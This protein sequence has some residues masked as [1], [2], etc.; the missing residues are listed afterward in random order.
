[1]H[2]VERQ[3]EQLAIAGLSQPIVPSYSWV[4]GDVSRF[5]LQE[6][7]VVLVPGGARHRPTKRWPAK[8][9]KELAILLNHK[10]F[11]TIVIGTAEEAELADQIISG[12]HK[13]VSLAGKT[14]LEDLCLLARGAAY[15]I[16]NDTG[17]LHLFSTHD[18]PSVVL[19][20][21]ASDPNLC[22]P[23]GSKVTILRRE[24]L[25]T[26]PAEAVIKVLWEF[27]SA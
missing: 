17:P 3:T 11:Q 18:C 7:Y 20:S 13:G 22:A 10:G 4:L 9:F 15:A 24:I 14:S 2:T 12:L 19:Y 6:P 1:M 8:H 21:H 16:G 5:G 26:I 27:Q 25:A 23:R